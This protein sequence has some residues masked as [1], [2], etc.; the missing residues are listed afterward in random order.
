MGYNIKEML[1]DL[2]ALNLRFLQEVRKLAKPSIFSK[3]Y[4]RRMKK[5]KRLV[6]ITVLLVL[7]ALLIIVFNSKIKN[8]DFTNIKANIQAWVDSDKPEEKKDSEEE[9]K[10]LEERPET[11][12]K[13][14]EKLYVD[15][16]V[17]EG[18][19]VKAEYIEE[20]GIKKFVEITP[21]EGYTFNIS[22]SKEKLLILDNAQ[23]MK[24][25]DTNGNVTDITKGSYISQ[26]GTTFMKETILQSNPSYIWHSQS[27]FIDEDNVVYVSELPYF[28]KN[29]TKK[30]VW[31]H[32]ISSNTDRTIWNFVGQDIVIG[33]IVP[34]KGITITLNGNVYY[35]NGEGVVVQ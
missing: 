6:T 7:A 21:I 22:P 14:P 5:R 27:K 12:E 9:A 25:S 15:I 2:Y 11:V 29:G 1:K 28:G 4:E 24:V 34:E 20:A 33:D 35:L 32:N 10:E 31:I 30:Y 16:N 17:A 19:T 8:L 3:D 23:N 26:A 13:K 18:I